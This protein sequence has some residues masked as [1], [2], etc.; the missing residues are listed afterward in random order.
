MA[1]SLHIEQQQELQIH[2]RNGE[3]DILIVQRRNLKTLVSRVQAARNL[4]KARGGRKV[5]GKGEWP[6]LYLHPGTVQ[7]ADHI[8]AYG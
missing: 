7:E 3:K 4:I 5:E 8:E 2:W 1:A 6:L